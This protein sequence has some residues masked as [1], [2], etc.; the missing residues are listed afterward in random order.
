M[1]FKGSGWPDRSETVVPGWEDL[2]TDPSQVL[3]C[4]QIQGKL[5]RCGDDYRIG[6]KGE[7]GVCSAPVDSNAE[8]RHAIRMKH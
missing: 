5:R 3:E 6:G 8:T 2:A 7:A 4:L 1:L